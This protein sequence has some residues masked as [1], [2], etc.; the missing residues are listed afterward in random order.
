MFV[1]LQPILNLSGVGSSVTL[2]SCRTETSDSLGFLTSYHDSEIKAM[3]YARF[4]R[5]LKSPPL[6]S[7]NRLGA[8]TL[9][10]DLRSKFIEADY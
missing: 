8:A 1:K 5:R 10:A 6:K 3:L 7:C 4:H 2:Y 9:V